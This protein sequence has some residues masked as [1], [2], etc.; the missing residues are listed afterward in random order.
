MNTIIFL[1]FARESVHAKEPL[2]AVF[3]DEAKVEAVE[4]SFKK[5]RLNLEVRSEEH[6]LHVSPSWDGDVFL[7][8]QGDPDDPVISGVYCKSEHARAALAEETQPAQLFECQ[9]GWKNRGFFSG[10]GTV[11]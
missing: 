7:I 4:E 8:L 2:I 6:P 1:V 9:I 10:W 3:D 5:N 11:Q